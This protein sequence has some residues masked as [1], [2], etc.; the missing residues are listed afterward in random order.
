MSVCGG[1]GAHE[2]V[3]V[4][5]RALCVGA[6]LGISLTA[7]DLVLLG[8]FAPFDS[9]TLA[10]IPSDLQAAALTTALDD[11]VP[12][13]AVDEIATARSP[14][15]S[16]D[17][18]STSGAVTISVAISD[19]VDPVVGIDATVDRLPRG[20]SS[21][22]ISATDDDMV[23]DVALYLDGLPISAQPDRD[24]GWRV[25][26]STS[27]LAQARAVRASATDPAGNVGTSA[28]RRLVSSGVHD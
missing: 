14:H 23:A 5:G 17:A 13:P 19:I 26:V 7:L 16:L 24:G 22:H 6:I 10:L 28:P 4:S 11:A 20:R 9:P 12:A 25:I 21:V 1:G 8:D 2:R 27:Q 3:R 15:E 18:V